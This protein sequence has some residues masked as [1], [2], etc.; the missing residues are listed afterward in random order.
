MVIM[1]KM[2]TTIKGGGCHPDDIDILSSSIITG[3]IL[4]LVLLVT[5]IKVL[6]EALLPMISKVHVGLRKMVYLIVI[7]LTVFGI[8]RWRYEA[9]C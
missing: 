7:V 5:L 3:T 8:V 9:W 1:R 2:C 6:V 4:Q